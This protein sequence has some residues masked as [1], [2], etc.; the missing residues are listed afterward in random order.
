MLLY[1][2]ASARDKLESSSM[3]QRASREYSRMVE[4]TERPL[5]SSE[6]EGASPVG[7]VLTAIV[8]VVYKVAI[9]IEG[10]FTEQIYLERSQRR[11]LQ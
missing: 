5:V 10:P 9:R 4:S 7:L 2:T 8:A 3:M 11:K 1:L 6:G